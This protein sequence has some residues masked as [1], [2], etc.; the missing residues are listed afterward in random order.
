MQSLFAG[1]K[2]RRRANSANLGQSGKVSARRAGNKWSSFG[3]CMCS[4][5]F[6]QVASPESMHWGSEPAPCYRARFRAASVQTDEKEIV[7]P[8]NCKALW[9]RTNYR[10]WL[11]RMADCASVHLHRSH[12]E[13]LC[14]ELSTGEGR[15][16]MSR[17]QC[18]TMRN[19]G[20]KGGWQANWPP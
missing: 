15:W 10:Q 12:N 20:N 7:V 4:S 8:W 3:G 6:S 11:V 1:G 14:R 13:C 17:V 9:A 2:A 18:Q 19:M 16:E 5:V